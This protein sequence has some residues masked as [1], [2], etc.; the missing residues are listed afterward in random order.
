M[1]SQAIDFHVKGQRARE[2]GREGP[3]AR[4]PA[5]IAWFNFILYSV[6][7]RHCCRWMDCSMIVF[8][9]VQNYAWLVL[10]ARAGT[11]ISE[12]G[13]QV[14]RIRNGNWTDVFA[15][16]LRGAGRLHWQPVRMSPVV[17]TFVDTSSMV[18]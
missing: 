6:I 15:V 11:S 18:N 3:W 17:K 7:L 8:F 9:A 1:L 16:E 14:F 10:E 4:V 2:E 5:G 13:A 12:Q